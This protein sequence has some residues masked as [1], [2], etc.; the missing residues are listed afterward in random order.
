MIKLIFGRTESGKSYRAREFLKNTKRKIIFDAAN[1]FTGMIIT[2]FSQGNLLKLFMAYKCSESFCLVFRPPWNLDNERAAQAVA[3]FAFALGRSYGE[4]ALRASDR[5]VLVLDEADKYTCYDK[6]DLLYLAVTK[7][8]HQNLD[9]LAI[10]QDPMTLPTYFRRNASEICTLQLEVNP[11]FKEKFGLSVAEKIAQLK[12]YHYYLWSDCHGV[13][14][15]NA[16]GS[17]IND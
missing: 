8:R 16:K 15:Y 17:K 12:R 7:G 2:D 9:I 10:C 3:A 1:D 14:L 11:Y 6:T 4:R 5:I 13:T